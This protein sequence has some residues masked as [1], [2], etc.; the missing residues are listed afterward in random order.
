MTTFVRRRSTRTLKLTG[1]LVAA[2]ALTSA[3]ATSGG[4]GNESDSS[5]ESGGGNP[6]AFSFL[7]NAENTTIPSILESLSED[8]CAAENDALPLEIETVPQ[9]QLDQKLQL[10]AGQ[11]ALPVSFAAGNTPQ[12]VQ[13]LDEAGHLLDFEATFEELGVSDRIN[14]AAVDTIKALYG[15][16]FNVLPYQYNIEGFWYNTQ[17]FEENGIE[18]PTTWAELE[19]AAAALDEAGIQPLSASGEQG[20]PLT[21]LISGY[22]FRDLGPDA[23]QAVADGGAEL[24]DP[25]YVAAAEEVAGLGEAGYFGEGLGSI[26]YDTAINSFMAGDAA[27]LYM[28]SWVTANFSDKELNKIGIDNI[29]FFRFPEVEGGEGS[30]A[31]TPANVGLPMTFSAHQYND[32]VGAWLT[33]IAENYGS[34]ALEEANSVSGFVPA[35]TPELDPLTTIVQE[36]VDAAE[37][38]VL[39]FEALFNSKATTVSQ[40]NAAPLVTGSLS[41]DEFMSKVQSALGAG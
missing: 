13:E 17:I 25:E 6:D 20:W 26:D 23:L 31:Q 28:G 24:T 5:G 22:L 18:V 1:S 37:G 15:G 7:V 38:S 19:E 36:E 30:A 4:G 27:M 3:C 8:E 9:T 10:L 41:P 21:R 40:T 16:N 29:D 34:V 33:C 35:E 39:W 14:P 12:L 11:D 2:L 32:E